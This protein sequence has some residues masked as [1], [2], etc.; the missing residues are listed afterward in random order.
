MAD[1]MYG[2]KRYYHVIKWRMFTF[3]SF[4]IVVAN[5]S[6]STRTSE[7]SSG[8]TAFRIRF[9]S[10]GMASGRALV[11][12]WMVR[13][14]ANIGVQ[15]IQIRGTV[16]AL[17]LDMLLKVNVV[18]GLYSFTSSTYAIGKSR[19]LNLTLFLSTRVFKCV[20]EKRWHHL[21]ESH[22]H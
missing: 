19:H 15:T 4:S 20:Q 21:A 13:S 3:T 7:W 14:N 17:G 2:L 10:T 9:V 8:I 16:S 22:R 5:V 18:C 12:I 1:R 11:D 6:K